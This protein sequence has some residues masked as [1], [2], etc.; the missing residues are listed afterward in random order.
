M[1]QSSVFTEALCCWDVEFFF[2]LKLLFLQHQ[3]SSRLSLLLHMPHPENKGPLN[4]WSCDNT[5]TLCRKCIGMRCDMPL[6]HFIFLDR[7]HCMNIN[8]PSDFN[9]KCFA[10]SPWVFLGCWSMNA[11][12]IIQSCNVKFSWPFL[13]IFAKVF[14]CILSDRSLGFSLVGF[15]LFARFPS[16]LGGH[17]VECAIEIFIHYLWAETWHWRNWH[18]SYYPFLKIS[19]H[20]CKLQFWACPNDWLAWLLWQIVRSLHPP[21]VLYTPPRVRADSARTLRHPRTVLGLCSDLL[22]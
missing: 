19:H 12:T 20:S 5:W 9:T 7:V 15:G 10:T 13:I 4:I 1:E 8:V 21:P 3:A 16:R 17:F 18:F 11:K 22:E 2:K 6:E 14:W